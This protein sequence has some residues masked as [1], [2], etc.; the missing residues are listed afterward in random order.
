MMML[1]NALEY[2][3]NNYDQAISRL[4]EWLAIP[5]VSTDP[6]YK[7]D[8]QR[9]AEWAAN[10]LRSLELHT[11]TIA[12]TGHPLVY[13][14]WLQAGPDRPTL[15]IYGHYDVQPAAIADGWTSDPFTPFVRDG[16]VYARGATDDK[17]QAFA[18]LTAVEAWLRGTK[19]LP[20]NLKVILEGEEESGGRSLA[21]FV[22]EQSKRL[23]AD[24]C[25]LSDT[26]MAHID[27]PVITFG[28]RGIVAMEL[29]I[30]GPS[31][32]LHSGMYGG[33]VLNPIKALVDILSQLHD[34]EGRVAVPHF[35][36][37]VRPLSS[38]ERAAMA[39]VAYS[40]AQWQQE[41]GAPIPWG[42]NGYSLSER[43]GA[44]PTL[45][46]NGISGGYAGVGFKAVIPAQ[47]S[48]KISC[49]LVADQD[50]LVIYERVK[51]TVERLTPPQVKSELR[52]LSSGWP[53]SVDLESP[54]M[55]AAVRAYEQG[56]GASPIFKRE[57]GS[58]P[59]V[60]DLQKHLGMPVIMMGF[61]LNSDGLHGPNEHFSLEMFRRGV[62][63]AIHFIHEFA[64]MNG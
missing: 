47:A 6:A 7:A 32:D 33:S 4:I 21:Q 35:Y 27:Q 62:Q 5:S 19:G 36:D 29:T 13:A 40:E 9:A 18:Q 59:I 1:H 44:R 55:R 60:A 61:G 31:N 24:A 58:L 25:V 42:E 37:E 3:K 64:H 2:A 10:Y 53:A 63:T 12:T 26:S 14:E 49:R 52:Y 17:G 30:Q 23:R 34:H 38:A 11:E 46:I 48:A 28:V 51:D 22:Q 20:L 54:A 57:G 43:I 50:P 41:T 15:L 8:V 16:L 56:W 39:A 45:E